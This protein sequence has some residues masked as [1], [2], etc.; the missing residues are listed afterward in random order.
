[1]EE[2][3][4]GT[5]R[6]GTVV[7]DIPDL[8]GGAVY[9][10][11]DSAHPYFTNAADDRLTHLVMVDGR[12]VDV[13]S[14]PVAGTRWQAHAE[15]FDR[16]LRRPDPETPVPT[17]ERALRWLDDVCG[18]RDAVLALDGHPLV[19]DG[20]DLPEAPTEQAQSRLAAVDELLAA[21]ARKWFDVESS[22]ALRAALIAVWE[23]E[24]E[25]VLDAT[26][27]AHVAGGICWAVGK[28]NAL[29]RPQGERTM[30]RVQEALAL[31]TTISTYGRVVQRALVGYRDL[32]SNGS[33]RPDG[34]ELLPLGRTDLLLGLVRRRLV[35]VRVRALEAQASTA[36]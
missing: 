7:V 36:A 23:R 28:A 34:P 10:Y 15:R 9:L 35:R 8:L 4:H 12:L 24:P 2:R 17:H 27:A 30:G 22:H 14:E 3:R 18:S 5:V 21:V 33:W 11:D 29:Y 13:W 1:V 6:R 26:T 19:D 25:V 31:H 32:A 16:E 20:R